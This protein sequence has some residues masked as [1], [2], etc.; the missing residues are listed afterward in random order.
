MNQKQVK[1]LLDA[2]NE[3]YP[4]SYMR[5]EELATNAGILIS[6]L[7]YLSEYDGSDFT[8][9][10]VDFLDS[11]AVYRIKPLKEILKKLDLNNSD[12]GIDQ[13]HSD[14]IFKTSDKDFILLKNAKIHTE[15]EIPER[16]ESDDEQGFKEIYDYWDD[17]RNIDRAI[18]EADDDDIE[19]L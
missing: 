5:D 18:D 19:L 13:Y 15:I 1:Q 3:L 4:T 17:Q 9:K 8:Y 16:W 7:E 2:D 10:D 14:L 11:D 12:H 6:Q